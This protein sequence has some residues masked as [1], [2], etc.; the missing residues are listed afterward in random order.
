MVF[1]PDDP[2]SAHTHLYVV[3]YSN[4]W[5]SKGMR[6]QPT[7]KYP[8]RNTVGR[9]CDPRKLDLS[10]IRNWIACC[11][12]SH[13]DTCESSLADKSP[14]PSTPVMYI[15]LLDSCLV[16]S[17]TSTR[18][19]ALSYVW[20]GAPT[21]MTFRSNL[22][23]HSQP[24]ALIQKQDQ[25][26]KTIRDS[27]IL[28]RDLGVRYLWVDALCIVQDDLE[29]KQSHLDHMPYIYESA[30]FTIAV[31]DGQDADS[32]IPGV[33]DKPSP[34]SVPPQILL[35]SRY[36]PI[37]T[38]HRNRMKSLQRMGVGHKPIWSTRAWTMQE[39]M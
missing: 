8:P 19:V 14:P 22:E 9:L 6:L 37:I 16:T 32:G 27:M 31:V 35:P 33:G 10:S 38:D 29:G 26:P 36:I 11:E 20:G 28:T 34:R 18:Y 3:T 17:P 13:H 25:L 1:S 4:L 7:V 12:S 30:Y 39:Q 24:G 2:M 15:D 23:E 21:L 5:L